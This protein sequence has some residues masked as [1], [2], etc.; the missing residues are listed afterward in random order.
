M[1]RNRFTDH[2]YAAFL[3]QV[4]RPARYVGGEWGQYRKDWQQVQA[5]VC[6]AFPDLY[7]LGM[8]H[9]GT[10]ILYNILNEAPDVLCERAFVPWQDMEEQL[11]AWGLPLVS[12]ESARPLRD[13]DVVGISLQHELIFTNVLTLLDLG[14]IALRA[15]N[16][17]EHDP[18]VL[19][20]G[21]VA[22]HPEPVT[23]FF[24]AFV[25]GDGEQKA[26]EVARQW[27]S[28]V[29][30]GIPRAERLRRLAQLEGVYVPSLYTT[31]RDELSGREVVQPPQ[32]PALPYPIKRAF[33]PNLDAFPFPERFPTGG[34]EAV[35]ERFSV[36]LARGCMQGCRFC[37]AGMIFRP[38]RERH[39]VNV[40]HTIERTLAQSG[41]DEV[42]LTCLSPADY[43]AIGP[44]VR[45]V[46]ERTRDEHISLAV[47]SLRAYGLSDDTLDS[48]RTVR[49]TGLTFA[50]EAGTQRMRDVINKNVT[51][52]QIVATVERVL[53]RG[54][55]R[56]KLYFMIGLPTETDDDVLGIVDTAV[57]A[58]EAGRKG[59]GKGRKAQVTASVSTFVPKPHT[60][61]Q[62]AAMD[63]LETVEDKQWKL[64]DRAKAA[65]IDL[66]THG[67]WGSILEGVLAR[68]DRRLADVIEHAWRAGARFDAWDGHVRWHQWNEALQACGLSADEYLQAIPTDATLAWSH[69][70]VGV[71]SKFLL[72]EWKKAQQ[73]RTSPPCARPAPGHERPLGEPGRKL[74][75]YKCGAGCDLDA[76]DERRIDGLAGLTKLTPVPVKAP[77]AEAMQPVRYRLRFE[78]LGRAVL[79]GHLDLV[80]EVPRILRRAGLSLWYSKGF[81][82][83]PMMTFGP[84]LSLGVPS[85]DEYVDIKLAAPRE[86]TAALDR[87]NSACPEGIRFTAMAE[88]KPSVTTV[89]NDAGAVDMLIGLDPDEVQRRGGRDWLQSRIEALLQAESLPVVRE[90]KSG[91]RQLDIR[92]LL[93]D[94]RCADD[95]QATFAAAGVAGHWTP[96]RVRLAIQQSA[97]AR[98][99]EIASYLMEH[100]DVRYAAV[101]LAMRRSDGSDLMQMPVN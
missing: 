46:S 7:D 79:L 18:L 87:I 19:G 88:L 9:L 56:V 64:R 27:A 91:T 55:D 62:W 51:E 83:K 44:L 85:F 58:R 32:D 60:P 1:D 28:D 15:A 70:D 11:R 4:E 59:R 77:T 66:K 50:P 10:R 2:P 74:V 97:S 42:S 86:L 98:V 101:R 94:A 89:V 13:F 39:P 29:R 35:F 80:R 47:S 73:A 68:G 43:S 72:G 36:E 65:R 22:T 53:Q 81:H 5:R 38:E 75:C 52:E 24:D 69:I 63:R 12:L 33:V 48:I 6:L 78:K 100:S 49:A 54:W 84:A 71:E 26:L 41:Q 25:V 37:Q 34:P 95:D 23:P 30:A 31:V 67:S 57:R 20:G 90:G 96:V 76:V 92:P 45:S 16:R 93:L 3:A 82:P 40:L 14:G 8:S 21:S 61:F 99:D 17:D